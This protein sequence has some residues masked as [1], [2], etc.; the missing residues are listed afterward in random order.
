MNAISKTEI[1]RNDVRMIQFEQLLDENDY[2][3]AKTA[4]VTGRLIEVTPD[5]RAYVENW[6]EGVTADC[7]NV[8]IV[9]VE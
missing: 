1:E 7:R 9:K 6:N 8:Q 3:C 2:V 5:G 4:G